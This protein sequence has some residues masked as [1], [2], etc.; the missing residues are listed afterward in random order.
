MESTTSVFKPEPTYHG[1]NR[2]DQ[3]GISKAAV[4]KVIEKGRVI[5]KQRLKYFF[6]P[7]SFTKD[8]SPG[9][10]ESVVDLVV[11]TDLNIREVITCYRHP[12]AVH[13]IKKK[14]KRLRKKNT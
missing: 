1:M 14:S 13:K 2:M 3:R 6:V 9:D 4:E 7:K 12:Q 10:Q 8:W 5:H 11:I